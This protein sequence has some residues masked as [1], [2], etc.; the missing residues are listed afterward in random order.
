MTK[1]TPASRERTIAAINSAAIRLLAGKPTRSASL[2]LTATNLALEA[3]IGRATLNRLPDLRD[4]FMAKVGKMLEDENST[5]PSVVAERLRVELQ[6][7]KDERSQE[8][9]DLRGQVK[10]LGN[11]VQALTLMLNLPNRLGENVLP[12]RSNNSEGSNPSEPRRID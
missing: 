4:G 10:V 7:L 3:G 2:D 9:S 6:R 8:L 1:S 12:F 5:H 11:R